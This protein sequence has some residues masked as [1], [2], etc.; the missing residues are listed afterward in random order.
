MLCAGAG[1]AMYS[2]P[3]RKKT[4]PKTLQN[5]WKLKQKPLD[6]KKHPRK[7]HEFWKPWNHWKKHWFCTSVDEQ[8]SLT[9]K[10]HPWILYEACK[11]IGKS[12]IF[13]Y[14]ATEHWPSAGES[15][16]NGMNSAKSWKSMEK[17]MI[18]H[19]CQEKNHRRRRADRAGRP[20]TA[21]GE[22]WIPALPWVGTTF[23]AAGPVRA[24][25]RHRTWQKKN[26]LDFCCTWGIKPDLSP[27]YII[28]IIEILYCLL[29]IP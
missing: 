3:G 16:F 23:A 14:L 26:Q 20:G 15:P 2:K 1:R 22:A 5:H 8:T 24:H 11:I 28:M 6:R 21:H 25:G 7:R 17:A 19:V 13:A 27:C 12:N 18:S 9:E 29:R 10:N 4:T